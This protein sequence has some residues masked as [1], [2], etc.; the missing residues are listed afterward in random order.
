MGKP[1]KKLFITFLF[2]AIT[3]SSI[4]QRSLGVLDAHTVSERY[5]VQGIILD[6]SGNIADDIYSSSFDNSK[7]KLQ[8][9]EEQK[10]VSKSLEFVNE[11]RGGVLPYCYLFHEDDNWTKRVWRTIDIDHPKN[12][13]FLKGE[14]RERK[15]LS[16]DSVIITVHE[17][18][19]TSLKNI[20]LFHI[21]RNDGLRLYGNEMFTMY[22]DSSCYDSLDQYWS[23]L[24][25]FRLKEDWYYDKSTG[26][27]KC[28]IVGFAPVITTTDNQLKELFW[29][30]YP[31]L[32]WVLKNI[33]VTIPFDRW[34]TWSE[35]LELH[36]YPS[37]ITKTDNHRD[38]MRTFNIGSYTTDNNEHRNDFDAL[39]NIQRLNELTQPAKLTFRNE[40][41]N[42]TLEDGRNVIAQLSAGFKN[43]T[44]AVKYLNGREQYNIK[45]KN[46]I[47][48][49]AYASYWSN[50]KLKEKGNFD[51]GLREGKWESFWE[52][53]KKL[54]VRSYK[55]G[56]MDGVQTI[57][58]R[59]G[60]KHL[61]YHYYDFKLNGSFA[62]WDEK[63]KSMEKGE[64]KNNSIFGHWEINLELSKLLKD[65]IL[66][67][68]EFDWGFPASAAKD[69]I[70]S[71]EM[72]LEHEY[73]R[74]CAFDLCIPI[75]DQSEV[76]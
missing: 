35:Y 42:D 69:G 21:K 73:N 17:R 36:N 12:E 63:G 62:R 46:D 22:R 19:E 38:H 71:Y 18:P 8:L 4:A 15:K 67:N 40:M 44:C 39:W 51:S 74:K 70:L 25:H 20:M 54:A 57:W 14:F 52:N 48:N 50:G 11:T 65:I 59:N 10:K 9:T 30:Y 41:W 29:I 64:F 60:K 31:E 24:H 61:E 55:K 3:I 34:Y 6:I 37:E 2:S 13:L 58:H 76:R 16:G 27:F 32:K 5:P 72:D 53:G 43:G 33:I 75:K 66:A 68:P 49:G 56:W 47:P 45:F 7:G 1:M 26:K 23:K 28:H